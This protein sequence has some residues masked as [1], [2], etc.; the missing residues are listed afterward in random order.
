MGIA[1]QGRAGSI[2]ESGLRRV[3]VW[4]EPDG[5]SQIHRYEVTTSCALDFGQRTCCTGSHSSAL[6]RRGFPP[7][8]GTDAP[9]GG[10]AC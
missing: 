7:G 2:G 6:F 1:L 10:V 9:T 8:M 5:L 4:L 3:L